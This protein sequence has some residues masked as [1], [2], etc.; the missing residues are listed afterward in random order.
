M[1]H[2]RLQP[3]LKIMAFFRDNNLMSQY[4][5]AVPRFLTLEPRKPLPLIELDDVGLPCASAAQPQT[6]FSA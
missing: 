4:T 3:Q 5:F 1:V 2:T 6:I